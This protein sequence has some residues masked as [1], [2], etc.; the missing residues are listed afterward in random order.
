MR[1]ASGAVATRLPGAVGFCTSDTVTPAVFGEWYV[2]QL[3]G[4]SLH[5]IAGAGHYLPFTHW[6]LLLGALSG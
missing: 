2:R 1:V 4:A 5:V 3:P 6:S